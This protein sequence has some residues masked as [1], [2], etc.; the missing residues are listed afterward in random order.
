MAT[1]AGPAVR[2]ACDQCETGDRHGH[3][4]AEARASGSSFHEQS[5][6]KK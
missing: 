6:P 3:S 1:T 2:A 5:S 4:H